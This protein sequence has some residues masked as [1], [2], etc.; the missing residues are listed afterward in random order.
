MVFLLSSLFSSDQA[1]KV[2]FQQVESSAEFS[3][4]K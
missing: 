2:G 4:Q 1:L 3:L